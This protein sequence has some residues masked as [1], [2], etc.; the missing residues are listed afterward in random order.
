MPF[1]DDDDGIV[2]IKIRYTTGLGKKGG[3]RK[4]V[5][6]AKGQKRVHTHDAQTGENSIPINLQSSFLK[7][8]KTLYE[9]SS[10]VINHWY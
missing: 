7:K 8:N 6:K 9:T 4:A 10:R 3:L 2:W 1:S 5:C